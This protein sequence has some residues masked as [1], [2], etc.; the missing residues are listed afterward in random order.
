MKNAKKIIPALAMLLV[1]AVM[2]STA[3]FAWF[4][5]SSEATANGMNVVIKSNSRYLLIA[6]SEEKLK[7]DN[8]AQ[9]SSNGTKD[10]TLNGGTDGILP[11]AHE[12]NLA[13]A[14]V[15]TVS[16]WYTMTAENSG[17]SQGA[18]NSKKSLTGDELANHVVKYTY[19]L[20]M[21]PGSSAGKDLKISGDIS[22]TATAGQGGAKTNVN[23]VRVIVV[24]D[25]KI[26]ELD[27]NSSDSAHQSKDET[28]VLAENV[29]VVGSEG[30]TATKVDV[31][32]YYDGNDSN[33]YTNNMPALANADIS[34]K[35][36]VSED[37]TNQ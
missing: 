3:S 28:T 19:Y 5:M 30:F 12:E 31:Y 37:T 6:E 21:A 35:L 15:G 34:F 10:S 25:N 16:N 22:I 26:T 20:G 1:S 36:A 8:Y 4:A 17:T 7:E 27:V 24:C 32:I 33:L 2:L 18:D 23:P 14:G 9:N 13:A 29:G 11:V